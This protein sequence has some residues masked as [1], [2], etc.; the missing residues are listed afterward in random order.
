[1]S[2]PLPLRLFRNIV[3][4][5][6]SFPIRFAIK[7]GTFQKLAPKT[8]AAYAAPFPSIKYKGG[9]KAFPKLLPTTSTDPG[10]QRM[11]K[12][13]EVLSRWEKPALVLFSDKDPVLSSYQDFFF[14]LIPSSAQQEK[15]TIKNA[16]HFLQEDKGEE[17]ARLIDKFIQGALEVPRESQPVNKILS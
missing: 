5:F 3:G 14:D 2:L 17:I 13:R 4:L 16:G 15:I 8:L 12:A 6:P 1:D 11:K 10:A 9:A 7:S